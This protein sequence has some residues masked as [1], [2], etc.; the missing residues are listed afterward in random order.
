MPSRL[1]LAPME[2]VVDWVMR[3]TLSQIG[4]IDQFVTEFLR[5]T[6][7]LHPESVFYRNCPELRT[8]SRTRHGIPVFV[9]LLGGQAE[10]LAMNARRAV[11]LGALGVDLNFGC[12]AK[13]VNRHDGGASLLKSCDRIHAIVKTVRDAVPS[14][15]PVTAKIRL[16]FEDRSACIENAQAIE[17]AGATWLTVHCRSK[18]DGYKPP[19]YWD[20]IPRIREVIKIPI[21]ANG[22]IWSV[23][24]F[25]RCREVTGCNQFMIGRGAMS[26]PYIFRQ[27]RQSETKTSISAHD[28]Q[29]TKN[30]LPGFFQASTAHINDYFAVSRTKQWLKALSLKSPEAKEVFDQIKI[31]RKP[32]EFRSQLEIFCT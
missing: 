23:E 1:L 4:G 14:S 13:T 10:P 21:I 5:V 26:N 27:L 18:T 8:G 20:W 19:A 7:K 17:E 3:D 6:D 24:D 2:G 28:W 31:L 12:P 25:E 29:N 32:T 11:K 16:G 30:L 22:D 9:Q 15:T